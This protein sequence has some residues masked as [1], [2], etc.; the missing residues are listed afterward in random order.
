[1][2]LLLACASC[3]EGYIIG[4]GGTPG[5]AVDPT[6]PVDG[7][8]PEQTCSLGLTK[9]NSRIYRKNKQLVQN[10]IADVFGDATLKS[11]ESTL[12]LIPPDSSYVKSY[13]SVI[14][15]V[16]EGHVKAYDAL[17][18]ALATSI[19][20]NDTRL[21]QLLGAGC[22]SQTDF[23]AAGPC[24]T[25]LKTRVIE[26]LVSAPMTDAELQALRSVY[27]SVNGTRPE[28]LT[29][30]IYFILQ[31][32]GFFYADL[33]ETPN[34]VMLREL[35]R[36]LWYSV[37]D[38]ALLTHAGGP[39]GRAEVSELVDTMLRDPRSDRMLTAFLGQW[40]EVDKLKPFTYGATYLDGVEGAGLRDAMLAEA[41]DF[42]R[43]VVIEQR[44]AL[45]DLFSSPQVNTTHRGL[46]RIYA[47]AP[48]AGWQ[49]AGEN[50]RGIL[51][52]GAIVA[53]GGTETKPIM[54]GVEISR[55]ILCNT[56]S[57]PSA[58]IMSMRF[59]TDVDPAGLTTRQLNDARVNR[60]PC[61]GCHAS[62]NPF[63]H[64]VGVYDGL[65]RF[66]D[67]DRQYDSQ[68]QLIK[69]YPLDRELTIPLDGK[70][71]HV[72]IGKDFLTRVAE[73]RQ[74]AE[75]F[76]KQL[77]RF[78]VGRLETDTSTCGWTQMSG[79]NHAGTPL[80]DLIGDVL[81]AEFNPENRE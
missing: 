30:L 76:D 39:Q 8:P 20:S 69:S 57:S 22:T 73:S 26:P 13:E 47:V 42:I 64:G 65:G 45:M 46:S 62:I 36:L 74:I 21:T 31:G 67:V 32:P 17:A 7:P 50:R 52:R 75:C 24:L 1:M 27:Q 19:A 9:S 10:A 72:K 35:A 25:A 23:G 55:Q 41:R 60:Q 63:G 43:H 3:T 58:D 66:G 70:E 61:L 49:N 56:I 71:Q 12:N 80:V 79:R 37:P 54:R 34:L 4:P 48:A 28:K 6:L 11:V 18:D 81:K 14:N 5:V 29:E 40:L 78:L 38:A 53:T 51:S 77:Y 16:T 68:G 15:T 2:T 59:D 33:Q 44:G